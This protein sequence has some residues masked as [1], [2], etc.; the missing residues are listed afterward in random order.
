[1]KAKV[2]FFFQLTRWLKF[3]LVVDH[4]SDIFTYLLGTSRVNLVFVW[5]KLVG[6]R[7][8]FYIEYVGYRVWWAVA[9]DSRLHKV[10]DKACARG[11]KSGLYQLIL[12][13]ELNVLTTVHQII[14]ILWMVLRNLGFLQ[15]T[16]LFSIVR[17][18]IRWCFTNLGK[19]EFFS[20][21]HFDLWEL[22]WTEAIT[23]Q[24][25]LLYLSSP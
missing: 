19:R 3:L 6:Y 21:A 23:S 11:S 13:K 8:F 7:I 16:I 15:K 17:Q 18:I 12:G 22:F 20:D 14:P 10:T 4:I 24:N 1:M 5:R 9:L 25:M 2:L